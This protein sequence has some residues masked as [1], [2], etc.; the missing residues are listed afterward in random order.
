[1]KNIALVLS[2]KP[3]DGGEHRYALLVADCLLQ[4]M[5]GD[6][7]LLALCSNRFWRSWC[8]ENG[9]KRFKCSLP[10]FT[11]SERE[12][13]CKYPF[14][15]R[16]Y[17]TYITPLGREIR[18]KKIDILFSLQQGTF[19][20]DYSKKYICPVHDLMHRYEP[21]FSE[22]SNDYSMREANMKCLAKYAD[23]ILVDSKLGRR[24]FRESYLKS[25]QKRP[26]VISLPFIAPDFRSNIEGEY[27]NVPDKYVFYPAQFWKHKN[28]INLVKAIQIL[29]ETMGDIHLVL[30]GSEKNNCSVVKKYIL[31][32][33]LNA[34]ITIL[35]FVSDAAIIY[36]YRHAVG[37]IMP[38]FFGPT[39]IPPLEAMALGCPVAVSN[40]YA[41]PEQVG[42]AGLL[43]DPDSP[44]EI[45]DCIR[46]LWTDDDLRTVLIE[47]GYRRV[48]RWTKHE[49]GKKL[50][51]ILSILCR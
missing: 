34:Y 51:K 15:A 39:N 13:H 5:G 37:M 16:L 18:E 2:T 35:G 7:Q 47:R 11:L 3:E 9:I 20:P 42:N 41:M 46:Q 33:G 30:V 19:I 45:A 6:Y 26:Y 27:V 23:C 50:Q 25:R 21:N 24:Q 48:R 29:S 28:H 22:V 43:F 31:E 17:Y 4:Q 10:T 14:F 32:N 12:F 38:S 49:F 44:Q 1:M 40:K 8:K 36:L